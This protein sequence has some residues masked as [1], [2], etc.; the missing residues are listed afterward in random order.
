MLFIHLKDSAVIWKA[1]TVCSRQPQQI[2][3]FSQ[4]LLEFLKDLSVPLIILNLCEGTFAKHTNQK[5]LYS[6]TM[7]SSPL[8]S[9]FRLHIFYVDFPQ[10]NQRSPYHKSSSI[11]KITV[12]ATC[13]DVTSIVLLS[14]HKRT[15]YFNLYSQLLSLANC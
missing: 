11:V 7:L 8:H 4:L 3:I 15:N 9:Q 1:G 10:K 12:Q 2:L 6:W 13:F 5:V 14:I